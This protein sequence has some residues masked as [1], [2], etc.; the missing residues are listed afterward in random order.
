M[1]GL[2]TCDCSDG[3]SVASDMG[4][5]SGDGGIKCIIGDDVEIRCDRSSFWRAVRLNGFCCSCC[6]CFA[7]EF[8][9]V[10]NGQFSVGG[11]PNNMA[12]CSR[13]ALS[14]SRWT[15]FCEMPALRIIAASDT[16][17]ASWDIKRAPGPLGVKLSA[18]GVAGVT[19]NIASSSFTLITGSS[20]TYFRLRM[21][22]LR[23]EVTRFTETNMMAN[24]SMN[25][26]EYTVDTRYGI[27]YDI[28]YNLY[29]SILC[30]T[31]EN[32]FY[33]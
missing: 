31:I 29:I 33:R 8:S 27:R 5:V 1:D 10:G 16:E 26:I 23:N 18:S 3:K 22:L 11:L 6:C 7:S 13:A 32:I 20:A 15:L 14:D 24:M 12:C 28:L 21:V 4:S 17:M 19:P 25:N 9:G 30:N 2:K